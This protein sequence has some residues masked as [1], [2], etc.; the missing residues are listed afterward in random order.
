MLTAFLA[1]VASQVAVAVLLFGTT[2]IDR[3]RSTPR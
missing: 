1:I 3:P 2:T